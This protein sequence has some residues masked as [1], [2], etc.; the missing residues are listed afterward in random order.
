MLVVGRPVY[1]SHYIDAMPLYFPETSSL[2]A[3]AGLSTAGAD[4]FLINRVIYLYYEMLL[5]SSKYEAD[6]DAALMAPSYVALTLGVLIWRLAD[7][8]AQLRKSTRSFTAIAT[9]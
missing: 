9:C 4:R 5:M 7:F 6:R 8:L 1:T 3:P 2:S